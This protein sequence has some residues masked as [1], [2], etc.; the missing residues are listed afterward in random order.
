MR[1]DDVTDSWDGEG[2][3]P[4]RDMAEVLITSGG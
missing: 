4:H 2:L 3:E 1:R